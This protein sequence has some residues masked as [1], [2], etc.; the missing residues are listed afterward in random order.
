MR[1]LMLHPGSR[2]VHDASMAITPSDQR[3]HHAHVSVTCFPVRRSLDHPSGSDGSEAQLSRHRRTLLRAF[4]RS[5][6]VGAGLR[7][8]YGWVVRSGRHFVVSRRKGS[9]GQHHDSPLRKTGQQQQ[10]RQTF[11]NFKF[12][13]EHQPEWTHDFTYQVQLR[14]VKNALGL[15]SRN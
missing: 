14:Y 12:I 9:S 15:S 6:P 10:Q 1:N 3:G 5:H 13:G 2:M 7:P 4:L 11:C 8:R